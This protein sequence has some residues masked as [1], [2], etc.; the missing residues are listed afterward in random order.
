MS[1]TSD[2]ESKIKNFNIKLGKYKRNIK[3][4][5]KIH[6]AW[7]GILNKV[8]PIDNES[9]KIFANPFRNMNITMN[10]DRLDHKKDLTYYYKR[11]INFLYQENVGEKQNQNK[12]SLVFNKNL[13]NNEIDENDA[14]KSD[15]VYTN[16]YDFITDNKTTYSQSLRRIALGKFIYSTSF[17]TFLAIVVLLNSIMLALQTDNETKKK[18]LTYFI[19]F[20]S[21]ANAVFLMELLLKW[22]YG[23]RV[24]WYSFWNLFDFILVV[25]SLFPLFIDTESTKNFNTG[26]A[27][28]GIRVVRALRSLRS[29]SIFYGLQLIVESVLKS[30]FD[31]INIVLLMLLTMVMLSLFGHNIFG[32]LAPKYFNNLDNGTMSLFY[33]ATREGLTDLFN[34]IDK[35]SAY[36]PFWRIFLIISIVI[37]AFVLTNLIVAV[38]VTNMEQALKEEEKKAKIK[39]QLKLIEGHV[40]LSENHDSSEFD[41]IFAEKLQ[42]IR[43]EEITKSM[44]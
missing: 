44:S 22:Y 3:I 43:V 6:K 16:M 9:H 40:D 32:H 8:N 11:I 28:G 10:M 1:D 29:L 20:E 15:K 7:I 31:M 17:Q 4:K 36:A 42:V 37:L 2:D 19:I 39:R 27:F 38:V 33:C 14:L 41:N 21:F 35:N 13:Y 30:A 24:Y 12:M 18:Y 34:E 23:F 26:R 25:F 5:D